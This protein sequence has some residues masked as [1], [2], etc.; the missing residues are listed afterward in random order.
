VNSGD[1]TRKG[2]DATVKFGS[3]PQ[4]CLAFAVRERVREANGVLREKMSAR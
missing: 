3:Q 4:Y 1:C 2:L